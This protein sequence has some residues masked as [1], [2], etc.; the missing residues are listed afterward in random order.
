MVLKMLRYP[1]QK[2]HFVNW[3]ESFVQIYEILPNPE[4]EK[5]L[6]E[7]LESYAEHLI[8]E[9][10]FTEKIKKFDV[11]SKLFN[12]IQEVEK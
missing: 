1:I 3:A 4:Y 10:E 7:H 12:L 2:T 8:S 11:D 6:I 5:Y 9:K